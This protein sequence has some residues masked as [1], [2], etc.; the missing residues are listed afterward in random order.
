MH[1]EYKF[2]IKAISEAGVSNTMSPLSNA[3]MIEA[4][5]PAGW[6]RFYSDKKKRFYYANVR[7][8]ESSWERPGLLLLMS[9]FILYMAV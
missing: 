4:A 2:G 5:L 7:T 3:V 8:K 1:H 9:W 6:F